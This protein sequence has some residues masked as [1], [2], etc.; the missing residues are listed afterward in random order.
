MKQRILR[1]AAI[2]LILHIFLPIY[3]A[4]TKNY[5]FMGISM[6]IWLWISLLLFSDYKRFFTAPYGLIYLFAIVITVMWIIAWDRLGS[7]GYI[8]SDLLNLIVPISVFDY[9]ISRRDYRGLNSIVIVAL[10]SV[11]ITLI[12]DI[13]VFHVTGLSS[14]NIHMMHATQNYVVTGR[15]GL[16]GMTYY[17]A[18]SLLLPV[19]IGSYKS[20]M[21]RR[22]QKIVLLIFI[23]VALYA[24]FVAEYATAFLIG[25]AGTVFGFLGLKRLKY[26]IYISFVLIAIIFYLPRDTIGTGIQ[27]VAS[28]SE[29]DTM[30]AR[31]DDLGTTIGN[32]NRTSVS[33]IDAR[34]RRI[35]YLL[36][37]FLSSPVIGGG[38]TTEHSFWLDRLSM[39]G[40]IGI[41]PWIMI[42]IYYYRRLMPMFD[43]LY[44]FYYVTTILLYVAMGIMKDMPGRDY[45]YV[46]F[47]I[48]PS[49]YFSNVY[50][51]AIHG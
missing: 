36:G 28:Q 33:H 44:K 35:P 8:V 9:F 46:M 49:V 25:V 19:V 27:Y 15:Y 39:Y 1:I 4:N 30:A 32:P 38:P 22:F 23:L 2:L 31:L 37:F 43:D 47:L 11:M 34:A 45:M 7:V 6:Y 14:R 10:V 26:S 21:V 20:L 16:S 24:L 40:I 29:G 12:V 18:I 5:S 50:E 41:T 42:F 51:K 17:Y 13:M 3:G 48:V